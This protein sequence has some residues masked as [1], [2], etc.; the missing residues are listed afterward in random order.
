MPAKKPARKRPRT[1]KTTTRKDILEKRAQHFSSEV[2]SIGKRL[3]ARFDKKG[4]EWDTW[5]HRTFGVV[6]PLISSVFGIVI[7]A[8]LTWLIG[9]VNIPIDSTFI[10]GIRLFLLND[11]GLFFLIF[12]FFSYT[13]YLS[14]THPKGY[15]P[16]SP[17]VTAAGITIAFWVIAEVIAIA[18]VTVGIAFFTMLSTFIQANLHGIFAFFVIVG[19]IVFAAKLALEGPCYPTARSRPPSRASPAP[20]RGGIKRLYRSGNDRLLGGVCGGIAEYLGVDP[21]LIRLL[22]VIFILL[23]GIGILAYIIAWIIIPRNPR[24]KWND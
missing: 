15:L 2:E 14:K 11:M 20:V 22:W 3:E 18:N 8:L 1:R 16:F 12:L 21:V 7:L 4:C 13:S 6:G 5:F 10:S 17:L 23:W 9:L 24:H 19:Y